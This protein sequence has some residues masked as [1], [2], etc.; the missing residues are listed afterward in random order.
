MEIKGAGAIAR[1]DAE[2]EMK[3]SESGE[4]VNFVTEDSIRALTNAAF[5]THR[6][7]LKSLL[8]EAEIQHVGSTAVPGSLTKG[9][10]DIQLR[11]PAAKFHA[12]DAALARYYERNVASTHSSTFSSF[13]D[14][15]TNPPLG[16]QL[17]VIG[18]PEDK[19]CLLRD[20]LL[21]HPDANR[22]YNVDRPESRF[23]RRF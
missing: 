16:L 5:E 11:V 19:F 9:D 23:R 6:R 7:R 13:K 8:P 3:S 1:G 22:S 21:A 4:R 20:H 17:T 2:I 18:G 10:L 15:R 12:A 14:D